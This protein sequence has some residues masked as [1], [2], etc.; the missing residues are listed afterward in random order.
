MHQVGVI[1]GLGNMGK[2]QEA[3]PAVEPFRVCEVLTDNVVGQVAGAAHYSLL[4]VPRVG[5]HLQ[6][7]QIVIRL[8]N[9]AIRF[10]QVVFHKFWQISQVGDDGDLCSVGAKCVTDRIGSVMWN[11]EWGNFDVAD[12]ESLACTNVLDALHFLAGR[13]GKSAYDFAAGRLR[14]VCGGAPMVQKLRQT[15]RVVRV[16]VRDQYAVN[17][18]WTFPQRRQ[19]AQRFLATESRIHQKAGML[20]FEQRSVAGTARRQDG[21]SEADAPSLPP[22]ARNGLRA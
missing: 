1:I 14:Q 22:E 3:C 5:P 19:A 4:D 20:R 17:S 16:L 21:N 9:Q 2:H 7:F 12:G 18:L 10:A 15:A 11:G 6:H 13:F 8:Q